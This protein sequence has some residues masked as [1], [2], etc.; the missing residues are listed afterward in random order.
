ML[1]AMSRLK[2]MNLTDKDGK[3]TEI[4][5][6]CFDK[7]QWTVRYIALE[8]GLRKQHLFPVALIG[9]PDWS[10]KALKTR[11]SMKHILGSPM[12]DESKPIAFQHEKAVNDYFQIGYYW[13]GPGL[14]GRGM[15]PEAVRESV[16][17]EKVD[18]RIGPRDSEKSS[19]LLRFSELG[20]YRLRAK[21]GVSGEVKDLLF[22]GD[23]WRTAY[24]VVFLPDSGK[25]ILLSLIWKGKIDTRRS[26]IEVFL[27]TDVIENTPASDPAKFTS[28]AY[29]NKLKDYNARVTSPGRDQIY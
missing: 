9:E 15:Y 6:C 19:S 28:P 16:A 24:L 2:E 18:E 25:W 10:T 20:G 22:D 21:D 17:D 8:S 3:I 13:A 12:L 4:S 5:D 23:T 26:L 7:A 1:Y 14:W 11:L 27:E 29:L